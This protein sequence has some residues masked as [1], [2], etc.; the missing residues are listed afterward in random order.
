MLD[1]AEREG[2]VDALLSGLG[3]LTRVAEGAESN[4]YERRECAPSVLLAQ[5]SRVAAR[6]PARAR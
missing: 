5:D 2:N 3:A 6:I 4:P 1:H